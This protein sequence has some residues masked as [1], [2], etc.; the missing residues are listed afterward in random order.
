LVAS[1]VVCLTPCRL[2]NGLPAV[3]WVG[4]V[5]LEL[6]AIATGGRIVPRFSE[7]AEAKLG[8]AGL[9][10]EIGFGTTKDHMLVRIGMGRHGVC[11]SRV[12]R[13][14][15]LTS[16]THLVGGLCAAVVVGFDGEAEAWCWCWWKEPPS[17]PFCI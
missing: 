16:L 13:A 6:I 4:G 8:R 10:R 1:C 12:C 2:Q 3:R 15:S 5:E 11:V 9:V 7:L 14:L 17:S